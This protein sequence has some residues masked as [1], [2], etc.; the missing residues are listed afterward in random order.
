[1]GDG[2]GWVPD[3]IVEGSK[4][5]LILQNPG[6][7]EEQGQR[8]TGYIQGKPIVEPCQH[9]PLTGAT[10]YAVATTWL[11]KAGLHP[12]NVSYLNILKCRW[13]V[14]GKRTNHLPKDKSY[15][16]AVRHCMDAH[17]R[18]P[19]SVTLLVACG[20]HAFSALGGSK[21]KTPDGK[22]A[23]V[24]HYRGYRL[25]KPVRVSIDGQIISSIQSLHESVPTGVVLT[26]QGSATIEGQ[27]GLSQE[28]GT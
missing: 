18:V 28:Q 4:V 22:P 5:A 2:R 3:R 10:G 17:F 15:Y 8:V 13:I 12:D 7:M 24:V 1:L 14:H 11:P 26:E 9:E 16:Q 23:T 27:Y 20:Q 6:Q 21:L 25:P 19:A